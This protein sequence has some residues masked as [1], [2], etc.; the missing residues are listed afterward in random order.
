LNLY[1]KLVEEFD[2][3][4]SLIFMEPQLLISFLIQ[5]LVCQ[6]YLMMVTDI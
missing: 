6:V 5:D 3:Q 4:L 1:Y 2:Y